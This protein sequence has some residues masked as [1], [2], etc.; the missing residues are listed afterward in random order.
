M[1]QE[2][3]QYTRQFKAQAVE[4]VQAGRRAKEVAQDLEIDVSC[5][6]D[7][8]RKARK[9]A[10]P[11]ASEL[12]SEGRRAVGEETEAEELRRLRRENQHLRVEN[13]ILKKAA[14]ILGTEPQRQNLR[15]S[16]K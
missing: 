13:D 8:L 3:K 1:S 7:W 16:G 4:L 11:A 12:R 14:I 15:R 6:Y 10:G 9:Q 5:L 2:R